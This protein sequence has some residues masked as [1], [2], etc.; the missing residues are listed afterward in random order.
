MKNK[1]FLFPAPNAFAATLLT[2]FELKEKFNF[3]IEKDAKILYVNSHDSVY[4]GIARDVG[5]LGGGIIRTFNNLKDPI[6]KSKIHIVYKTSP[7][8]SHPIA[9]NKRVKKEDIKK[10]EKAFLNMPS[11]LKALLSIKEFIKTNTSEYDSI[12]KI[13]IK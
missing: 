10:L 13:G 11:E 5:Y 7:Y 12:K 4:K 1:T 9:Y 6:D 3:D 8:P 2:K